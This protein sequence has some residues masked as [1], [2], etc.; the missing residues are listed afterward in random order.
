MYEGFCLQFVLSYK[1]VDHEIMLA[2]LPSSSITSM[3]E[4]ESEDD[5]Q[6]SSFMEVVCCFK[7]AYFYD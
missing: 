2:A 4:D 6:H 3:E 7:F 5:E 1:M